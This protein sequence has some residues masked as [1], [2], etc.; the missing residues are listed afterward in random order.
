ML[1]GVYS[2]YIETDIRLYNISRGLVNI[3]CQKVQPTQSAA[4]TGGT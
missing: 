4:L 3:A 1:G 2:P